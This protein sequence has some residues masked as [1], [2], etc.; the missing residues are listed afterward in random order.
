MVDLIAKMDLGDKFNTYKIYDE[1][2]SMHFINKADDTASLAAKLNIGWQLGDAWQVKQFTQNVL[3]SPVLMSKDRVAWIIKMVIS[4]MTELA[5]TVCDSPADALELVKSCVGTDFNKNYIKPTV[6]RVIIAEQADAMVDAY[7]Y[8][9]NAAASHGVNLSRMF[10]IVHQANM[11]K[12]F[13]DGEFHRREDGK[14]IKPPDW[15][16]PQIT[17]E[18]NYQIEHGAW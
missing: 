11:N 14:I 15:Q 8:M 10:Y 3:N 16:E 18:I 7:Y 4:E 17:S 9:L 2:V 12:R 6:E 13:P 1:N 5:Q